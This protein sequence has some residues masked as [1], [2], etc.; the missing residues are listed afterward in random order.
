RLIDDGAADEGGVAELARRLHITERHLH[1]LFVAELGAGPLAVARTRRLLLAKQLLT[2]T[3]LPITD[4][5]F[6]AGFGSVRQFNATMRETYGFPPS[7]LRAT[8][9]GLTAVP[10]GPSAPLRLRLHRREP[11]D[12]EAVLGFLAARAIPGLETADPA[13]YSRNVPG[14]TITLTPGP[15]RFTLDVTVD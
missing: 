2:E 6:A 12:V 13:S 14:G 9:G 3:A 1:R 7:E 8:A 11:Y 10:G 15:D 4:V 5:A